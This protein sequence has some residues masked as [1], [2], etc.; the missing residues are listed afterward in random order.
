M[1]MR[2]TTQSLPLAAQAPGGIVTSALPSAE[3][4]VVDC[5]GLVLIATPGPASGGV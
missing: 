2:S 3:V 4:S 1:F 5:V